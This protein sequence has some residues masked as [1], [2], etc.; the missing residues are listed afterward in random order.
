MISFGL[1]VEKQFVYPSRVFGVKEEVVCRIL[2]IP[3]DSNHWIHFPFGFERVAR[4]RVPPPPPQKK[5][6]TKRESKMVTFPLAFFKPTPKSGI[7]PQAN[8]EAPRVP[9]KK[10]WFQRPSG[11]FRLLVRG[12]VPS[13]KTTL[14]DPWNRDLEPRLARGAHHSPQLSRRGSSSSF[15]EL[16]L[17]FWGGFKGNPLFLVKPPEQNIA[18][19]RPIFGP[20]LHAAPR[21]CN[22]S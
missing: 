9:L 3:V 7:L 10:T 18:F 14:I 19:V 22:H 16:I 17:V 21:K 5:K 13:N 15:W 4:L 11:S 20:K 1:P 8:M 2:T 12:S 6:E